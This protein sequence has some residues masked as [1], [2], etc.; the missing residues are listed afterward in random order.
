MRSWCHELQPPQIP[1]VIHCLPSAE[2]CQE[3][4]AV[5][6]S[7]CPR[8]SFAQV[9]EGRGFTRKEGLGKVGPDEGEVFRSRPCR[10][11]K[12]RKKEMLIHKP[13]N[14]M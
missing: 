8:P 4:R 11:K 2:P 14:A 1:D 10:Q 9:I 5:S 3:E 6:G 13:Q 7:V 12:K